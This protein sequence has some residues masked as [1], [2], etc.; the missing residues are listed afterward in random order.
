MLKLLK[1]MSVI[2]AS[3]VILFFVMTMGR[4]ISIK[5]LQGFYL[6]IVICG[7]LWFIGFS[8]VIADIA[9]NL[10]S[11]NNTDQTLTK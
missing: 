6:I 2:N 10:K 11:N 8:H 4:E 5:E 3:V 9:S 1:V 7:M